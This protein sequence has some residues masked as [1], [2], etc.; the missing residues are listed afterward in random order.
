MPTG[1]DLMTFL[2]N[3]GS[4]L[5]MGEGIS[6]KNTCPA[7]GAAFSARLASPMFNLENHFFH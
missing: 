5:L 7:V 1:A 4:D 6:Q 2:Q 3:A